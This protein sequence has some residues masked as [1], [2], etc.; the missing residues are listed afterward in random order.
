ME[1]ETAFAASPLAKEYTDLFMLAVN[2]QAADDMRDSAKDEMIDDAARFARRKARQEAYDVARDIP[3]LG[4][5]MSVKQQADFLGM[6]RRKK[7]D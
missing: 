2:A 5:A 7:D 4:Q 6:F 3:G 1:F